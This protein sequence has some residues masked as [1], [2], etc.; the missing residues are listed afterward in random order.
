MSKL[1]KILTVAGVILGLFATTSIAVEAVDIGSLGTGA[2]SLALSKAFTAIAD[3]SGSILTNP[4]GLGFADKWS[5]STMQTKILDRANYQMVSGALPTQ[6]G[7]FGMAFMGVNTPA[8]YVNDGTGTLSDATPISYSDSMYVVSYGREVN[9]TPD[10]GKVAVGAN[11]KYYAKG[12]TGDSSVT[13]YSATGT[14]TDL[15]LMVTRDENSSYGVTLQNIGGNVAWSTGQNEEFESKAKVGGAWKVPSRNLL[16]TSDLDIALNG[17]NPA[18]VKIGTEWNP[19]SMLAIRAGLGQEVAAKEDGSI[20][21]DLNVSGGIGI[22]LQ[23]VRF[24][25][26]YKYDPTLAEN[27]T[28]YVS[29]QLTPDFGVTKKAAPKA[30]VAPTT[31][32]FTKLTPVL[33][34]AVYSSPL[35][36]SKL[37]K[38]LKEKKLSKSTVIDADLADLMKLGN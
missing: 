28:H 20:G 31:N 22:T 30:P 35:K 21:T 38:K 37:A 13:G 23:G 27:S 26:A 18:T 15:G 33:P 12:F 10:L 5:V 29:L 6:Y 9:N 32:D 17:N 11:I 7:T 4:A 1:T 16:I 36:T 3:D 34:D 25:Y 14:S 19:I 2:R 24:D 8:G